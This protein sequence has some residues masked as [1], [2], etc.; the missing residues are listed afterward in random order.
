MFGIKNL[1]QKI[2][3]SFVYCKGRSYGYGWR[4][5]RN[6]YIKKHPYCEIC[7]HYSLSNDVHHIAPKHLFPEKL[8]E[9]DNLIALCRKYKCH[10]RFGHF[11]N[12]RE[13]HNPEIKS[14]IDIGKIMIESEIK[15][16]Q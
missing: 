1:I 10:L 5:L 11:G 15:A 9:E 8:L 3:S 16:K 7:G 6:I 13:Y 14:L 2:R 4:K 12:Y